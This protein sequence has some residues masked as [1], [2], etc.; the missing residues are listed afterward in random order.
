MRSVSEGK[1]VGLCDQSNGPVRVGFDQDF[2]GV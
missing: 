1:D 2:D